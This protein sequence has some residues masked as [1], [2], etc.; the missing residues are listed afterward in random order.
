[1]IT[2]SALADGV[3]GVAAEAHRRDHAVADREPA[4]DPVAELGDRPRHLIADHAGRLGRIGIEPEAR[5]QVREVDPRG[6]DVDEHLAATGARIGALLD[7]EH[8]G[9]AVPGDDDRPHGSTG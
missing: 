8:L 7:V 4:V 5:H 1:M 6:A 3:I 9:S 2:P